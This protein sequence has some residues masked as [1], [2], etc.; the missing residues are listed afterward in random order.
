MKMATMM[1]ILLNNHICYHINGCKKVK[2]DFEKTRH[3][4]NNDKS[5]KTFYVDKEIQDIKKKVDI[6]K[7][8]SNKKK[9]YN[10]T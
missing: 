5:K 4:K 8:K 9:S 3:V 10:S 1:L 6:K 2:E 7:R